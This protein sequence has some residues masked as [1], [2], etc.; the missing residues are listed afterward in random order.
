LRSLLLL[1]TKAYIGGDGVDNGRSGSARS[2]QPMAARLAAPGGG[3]QEM[4]AAL[5]CT[6]AALLV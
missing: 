1:R 4:S 5:S 6:R 3:C 2:L